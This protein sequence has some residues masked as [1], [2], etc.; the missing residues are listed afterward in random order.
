M[1][2]R[3]ESAISRPRARAIQL[4][5]IKIPSPLQAPGSQRLSA[6]AHIK[7]KEKWAVEAKN[8][9]R[10]FKA[11]KLKQLAKDLDRGRGT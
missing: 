2:Y 9:I 10:V 5:T 4:P 6:V 1:A 8:K 3:E 7:L 11:A